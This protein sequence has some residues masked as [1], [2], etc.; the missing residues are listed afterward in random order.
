MEM[1]PIRV[2]K[3]MGIVDILVGLHVL[4]KQSSYSL[5]NVSYFHD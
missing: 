2:N 3:Q 5:G 1:I 4:V